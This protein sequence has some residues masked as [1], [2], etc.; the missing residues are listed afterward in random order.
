LGRLV[1]GRVGV[2]LEMVNGFARFMLE[3]LTRGRTVEFID[4]A[5]LNPWR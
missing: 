3:A 2:I 4:R 1:P 5:C